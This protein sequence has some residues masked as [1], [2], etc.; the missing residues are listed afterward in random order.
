MAKRDPI[1]EIIASCEAVRAEERRV[2]RADDPAS[3]LTTE[4]L[5]RKIDALASGA[6]SFLRGTF[7]V[8]AADLLQ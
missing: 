8:M 2:L 5:R 3:D 1:P 7:H 4:A 6:F